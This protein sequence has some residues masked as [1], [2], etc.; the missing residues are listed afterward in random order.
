MKRLVFLYLLCW[1]AAV[2]SLSAQPNEQWIPFPNTID[3][4]GRHAFVLDDRLY[5]VSE[6]WGVGYRVDAWDGTGWQAVPAITDHLGSITSTVLYNGATYLCG[7]FTLDINGVPGSTS[8]AKWDG[9]ELTAIEP[10]SG[11]EKMVEFQ[12]K[13]VVA[14]HLSFAATTASIA[15]WDGTQWEALWSAASPEFTGDIYC[16]AADGTALYVG[17]SFRAVGATTNVCVIAWDGTEWKSMGDGYDGRAFGLVLYNGDLLMNGLSVVNNTVFANM[18]KW[19]GTEWIDIGPK[20]AGTFEISSY[21]VHDGSLYAGGSIRSWGTLENVSNIVRYDGSEWHTVPGF[22]QEVSHLLS[23]NGALCAVGSFQEFSPG[24][25]AL[26]ARLCTQGNC[27]KISGSVFLD[28]DSDCAQDAGDVFFTNRIIHITPE[29]QYIHVQRD[30]SYSTWVLPGTYTVS[31]SQRDYWEQT[32]PTTGTH[33]VVVATTGT[34]VGGVNFGQKIAEEKE[35]LDVSLASGRLRPGQ[36]VQYSIRYE[37]TGTVPFSGVVRF[38]FDP[39]LIYGSSTPTADR[40]TGQELEWDISDLRIGDGGT[41]E[42]SLSVP[43]DLSLVGTELCALAQS[44]SEPSTVDD[45]EELCSEVRNS[46]DPNM[47]VVTPGGVQ[48]HGLIAPTDTVLNYVVHFQN[49]GNDTALKVVVMD[50]IPEQFDLST[51]RAGASSHSYEVDILPNREVRWTFDNIMLPDS[52]AS[53]PNSHGYVKY[54]IKLY[55]GLPIGTII[56]NSAAIYFDYNQPVLTNEVQNMIADLSTTSAGEE[57]QPGSN[58]MVFWPNP[59]SERVVFVPQSFRS[60]TITVY[61]AMGSA[62]LTLP[63]AGQQFIETDVS[64]LSAGMYYVVMRSGDQVISRT[65]GIIR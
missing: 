30:G 4:I 63:C 13:L 48:P 49:T 50:R 23:F 26:V 15:A 39:V 16:L 43:V 35:M 31:M 14:G 37:N 45:T 61:N 3:G 9:T 29:D 59:A 21:A 64:S 57:L 60:G 51:L 28:N 7:E 8:V 33:S 55:N 1:C 40:Y 25:A 24:R 5:V 41:I 12:G 27:G 18:M 53:E 36:P 52:N 17:G 62:V 65:L 56:Q 6:T 20:P 32:C 42:I 47:I 44:E 11:V 22:Q 19:N 2:V 10:I 54:A 58:H 46:F 34:S 38:V